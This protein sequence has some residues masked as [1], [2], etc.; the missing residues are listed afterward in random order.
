M[1][2]SPPHSL[3]L[4]S[5]LDCS[6]C[7]M[8]FLPDVCRYLLNEHV[9]KTSSFT[10]LFKTHSSH[11]DTPSSPSLPLST[12]LTQPSVSVLVSFFL[13]KRF[14]YLFLE[15]GEGERDGMKHQCVVASCVLP[16]GDLTCNP[17]MC[18]D[19][20]SNR[21]LWFTGQHSIH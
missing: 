4:S 9:S 7:Q 15:G 3:F 19:W 2:S 11:P 10:S 13:F 6:F 5:F 16:S 21:Q 18:P 12:S 17:G 20:E 14:T 1:L 8:P